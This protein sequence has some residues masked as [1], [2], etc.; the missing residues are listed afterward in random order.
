M[1]SVA[2]HSRESTRRDDAAL[3][4]EQRV[5]RALALG[6]DDLAGYAAAH[7]LATE[8]A[9]RALIRRRRA[10]RQASACIDGLTS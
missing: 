10:G 9:R 7:A 8:W 3:T 5:N 4:P 6:D 1:R 2:D